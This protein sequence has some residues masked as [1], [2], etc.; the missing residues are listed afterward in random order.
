MIVFCV[1]NRDYCRCRACE[2]KGR[3]PAMA[4]ED[5]AEGEELLRMFSRHAHT[6]P[7][8]GEMMGL[9][10]EFVGAG[11][12]LP[13]RLCES[14]CAPPGDWFATAQQGMMSSC[15][16]HPPSSSRPFWYA[17]TWV[18]QGDQSVSMLCTDRTRLVGR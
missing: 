8:N 12:H 2:D 9:D 14:S 16:T 7:I 15:S 13:S 6:I 17:V 5:W 10:H 18:F 1:F 3:T 4:G 11:V